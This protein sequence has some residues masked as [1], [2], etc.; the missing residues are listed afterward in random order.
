MG[1]RLKGTRPTPVAVHSQVHCAASS[2]WSPFFRRPGEGAFN[3]AWMNRQVMLFLYPLRQ[4]RWGE[5]LCQ[6]LKL[7]NELCG[8]LVG[9]T[10]PGWL[11]QQSNDPRLFP[12]SLCGVKGGTREGKQRGR[13]GDSIAINPYPSQELLFDLHQIPWVK[14]GRSTRK[15]R[16]SH[17]LGMR[18]K[19]VRLAQERK[20]FV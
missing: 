6:R 17:L 2:R 5:R 13:V 19:R 14:E 15:E 3:A 10:R 16:V 9:M 8:E 18:M 7:S 1:E 12:G 20:L 4:L 11:G